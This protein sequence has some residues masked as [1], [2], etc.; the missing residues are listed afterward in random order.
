MAQVLSGEKTLRLHYVRCKLYNADFDGDEMNIH[1]P[2]NE[3]RISTHVEIVVEVG[4]NCRKSTRSWTTLRICWNSCGITTKC[5]F[6]GH[7]IV[8]F[9]SEFG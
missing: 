7:F 6:A 2:Q 5:F 4:Q 8:H 3:C 1:L 9:P